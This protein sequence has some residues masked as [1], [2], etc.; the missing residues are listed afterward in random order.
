MKAIVITYDGT[1]I[2]S[3]TVASI[4]SCIS[5]FVANNSAI[6][7]TYTEND[8]SSL[9]VEKSVKNRT[10]EEMT[11]VESACV[12]ISKRFGTFFGSPLKMILAM[13]ELKAGGIDEEKVLLRNAIRILSGTN[14]PKYVLDKYKIGSS[15]LKVIKEFSTTY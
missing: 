5:R 7:N 14:L 3:D 4:V 11:P 13:G 6:V 9:C 2:N 12:Y 1:S 15:V 10:T 8:I